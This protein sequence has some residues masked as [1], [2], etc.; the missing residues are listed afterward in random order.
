[1]TNRHS[2]L[3]VALA[4]LTLS[5]S[6]S[7]LLDEARVVQPL[8]SLLHLTLLTVP[9]VHSLVTALLVLVVLCT[10]RGSSQRGRLRYPCEFAEANPWTA[11][12]TAALLLLMAWLLPFA[13]LFYYAALANGVGFSVPQSHVSPKQLTRRTVPPAGHNPAAER[14][15]TPFAPKRVGDSY[16]FPGQTFPRSMA[17]MLIQNRFK[18]ADPCAFLVALAFVW[19]APD[20][21]PIPTTSAVLFASMCLANLA[22]YLS[23]NALHWLKSVRPLPGRTH[24]DARRRGG[25]A[26]LLGE[27]FTSTKGPCGRTFLTPKAPYASEATVAAR[28]LTT[29][30][31]DF[32]PYLWDLLTYAV[33]YKVKMIRRILSY[34]LGPS[35]PGPALSHENIYMAIVNTS[36]ACWMLNGKLVFHD[37]VLPFHSTDLKLWA[38]IRL[39]VNLEAKTVGVLT[40]EPYNDGAATVDV[41]TTGNLA[42]ISAVLTMISTWCC[43][44]A[45][46]FRTNAVEEVTR[47]EWP[48]STTCHNSTQG[49]NNGA[50]FSTSEA[51]GHTTSPQWTAV[52]ASHNIRLGFPEHGA[53]LKELTK[54]RHS[55][56][57]AMVGTCRKALKELRPALKWSKREAIILATVMHAADHHYIAH[58]MPTCANSEILNSST[59]MVLTILTRPVS[60][61][62]RRLMLKDHIATD[63]ICKVLYEA[64]AAVDVSFAEGLTLGVLVMLQRLTGQSRTF[65]FSLSGYR[66]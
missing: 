6:T 41:I 5:R 62:S 34:D 55:K 28:G 45:V 66:T 39:Q 36:L 60:Y 51:N 24:A 8:A 13:I 59:Q 47:E 19:F 30:G 10:R 57:H 22:T 58:Y 7:T 11:V 54:I 40:M 48:L 50:V 42:E 65:F 27:A 38:E 44:P 4:V 43:H 64:C 21:L 18:L 26:F 14:V 12:A 46:H 52:M 32:W 35:T 31:M 56:T 1:M 9:Y 3:A 53:H 37:L 2:A 25:D 63:D 20:C 23:L 33:E 17:Q 61:S 29:T 16:Y 15:D 49:F